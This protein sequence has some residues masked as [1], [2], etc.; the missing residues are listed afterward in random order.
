M[1]A[2]AGFPTLRLV[3]YRIEQLTIEGMNPGELRVLQQEQVTRALF[4]RL[5]G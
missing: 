1:T 5:P 2:A 3:R 4:G